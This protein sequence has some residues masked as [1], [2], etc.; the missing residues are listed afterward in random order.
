MLI[1]KTANTVEKITV[2]GEVPEHPDVR[3]VKPSDWSA[4]AIRPIK[5][6]AVFSRTDGGPWELDSVTLYGFDVLKSGNPSDN[7]NCYRDMQVPQS[8]SAYKREFSEDQFTKT[9]WARDWA[10]IELARIN[11]VTE[12]AD[13]DSDVVLG[14]AVDLDDLAVCRYPDGEDAIEHDWKPG[15]IECRRCGVDLSTWN[16]EAE[17]S[18]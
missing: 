5:V 4:K 6:K 9:Q 10:Q 13:L 3:D 11:E 14:D 7:P 15:D 12:R 16:D 8:V 2:A 1:I 17:V 18:S